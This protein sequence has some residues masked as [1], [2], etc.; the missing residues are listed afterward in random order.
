MSVRSDKPFPIWPF[1]LAGF[2]TFA[3]L[4]AGGVGWAAKTT[5]AS[6][7]VVNGTVEN[8]WQDHIVQHPSG[9]IVARVLVREGDVVQAGAPL[10]TLDT[11]HE[12]KLLHMAEA[13][14][15]ELSAQIDRLMA[16]RAG[17]Q[18]VTF[19][20]ELMALAQGNAEAREVLAAERA[21][22][23][24]V[25]TALAHQMTQLTLENQ[26]TEARL[27][28]LAA[29]KAS[30]Q[31]Q[32]DLLSEALEDQRK[33]RSRGLAQAATVLGLEQNLAVL[34]GAVGD[35]A[36]QATQAQAALAQTKAQMAALTS[37]HKKQATER[38]AVLQ[39]R[40]RDH[41]REVLQ[42]RLAL[43]QGRITAPVSGRVQGLAVHHPQ[44]VIPAGQ[45]LAT[46]V[47]AGAAHRVLARLSPADIDAVYEGQPATL[48]L[49]ALDAHTTPE[50]AARLT[51]L[52]ASTLLDATTGRPYFEVE[53]EANDL[54][55]GSL[56]PGATLTAGMPVEVL[57]STGSGTPLAF[58]IK[59]IT[60]YFARALRES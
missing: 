6:A 14:V 32:I 58:L 57:I 53:I 54:E 33:L 21:T 16:Q 11:G 4:M 31:Q 1:A 29:Q 59:P 18:A 19:R 27:N 35:L 45:T 15:V 37:D 40:L 52:S 22:L 26:Q 43:E 42:Y 24:T 51:R 56:P 20:P 23:A 9:G 3:V 39:P 13:S 5:L 2:I 44:A 7:L 10:M 17:E 12:A 55:T 46:I 34:R 28:G 47:P 30:S 38:I 49:S 8:T 50:V 36:A 60:D 48:R 41:Q 25:Q